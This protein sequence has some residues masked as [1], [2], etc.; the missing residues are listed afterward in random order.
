M[1]FV[2]SI[3][4]AC[5]FINPSFSEILPKGD[6]AMA[7][8]FTLEDVDGKE[9]SLSDFKGKVVYMD[10][11][12]SWCKPCIQSMPKSEKLREEFKGEEGVVFLYVA[13]K[14]KDEAKWKAAIDKF[15]VQGVNLISRDEPGS[16][17]RDAYDTGFVPHYFLID[18]DGKM[19]D[20]EAKIPGKHGLADD[21]KALMNE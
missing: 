21:I 2:A 6:R 16:P 3:F 18:K 8:D 7:Y 4:I 1:K 11:W 5:L 20:P 13:V 19:A 10:L 17:F 12:G 14:E 15:N 9:V